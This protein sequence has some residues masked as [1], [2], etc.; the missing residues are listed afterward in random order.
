MVEE[1][2]RH[3]VPVAAHAHST[4]GILASVQAGVAS[5]E[6]AIYIDDEIM[7]L[8]KR[9]G[10]YLVPTTYLVDR[11]DIASFPEIIAEKAKVFLPQMRI[12]HRKAGVKI[13]FGTD[14]GVFPHGENAKEFTEYVKLG[15]SPL[16][17][18]QTATVNNA[19]LFRTLDRGRLEFG[20]LADIIAVQGNP[21]EDIAVLEAPV[22]VMLGG[23][24]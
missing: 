10:T 24:F 11:M 21:L 16:E 6:H 1:A 5:V 3:G 2:E 4:Q 18:L 15:L 14:A 9:R 8:M 20:L 13:A 23:R 7:A 17:A 19:E 12:S 22:F